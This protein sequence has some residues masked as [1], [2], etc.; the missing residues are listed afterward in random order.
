MGLGDTEKALGILEYAYG[1]HALLL[2]GIGSDP[3]Y[4]PLLSEPR[5][6]RVLSG[7]GL[8]HLVPKRKG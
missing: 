7:I 1:I 3:R 6:Q 5:F 8:E 2:S 4:A